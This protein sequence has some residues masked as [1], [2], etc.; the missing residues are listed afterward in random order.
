MSARPD[1]AGSRLQA[2]C[3]DMDGLLV[4]TESLWLLGEQE[5][6]QGLGSDWSEQDQAHC[7]GGPLTRVGQ[8][9]VDK[10]GHGDPQDVVAALVDR[11]E[12][13]M[14]EQPL[15]WQPGAQELLVN[16]RGAGIPRALVSASPR[17]LVNAVMAGVERDVG[18][19]AFDTTVSS[20]DTIRTKPD[21]DPYLEG[22]RRLGSD[23]TFTVILE[24]SPNGS[25]AGVAAGCFVIGVPHI[26]PITSGQRLINVSSLA[27]VSV[28]WLEELF[29]PGR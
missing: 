18:S 21:P 26:A 11:V 29:S 12:G 10:A 14:R 16:L 24:D 13:L 2:V 23:P 25:A 1:R 27:E 22:C 17:R 9:M 8:Y 5:V 6:M 7:L 4:E 28:S 19:N 20:N 15:E 3:F